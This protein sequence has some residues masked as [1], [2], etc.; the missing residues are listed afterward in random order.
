MY[1]SLQHQ[2]GSSKPGSY[3]GNWS[4][5]DSSIM[6]MHLFAYGVSTLCYEVCMDS[7]GEQ[8]IILTE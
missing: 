3:F 7:P 8:A 1:T 2:M 6:E 5:D 4:R